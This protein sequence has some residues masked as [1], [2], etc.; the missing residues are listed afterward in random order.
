MKHRLSPSLFLLA[1][2]ILASACLP[3]QRNAFSP[4]DRAE[5]IRLA[6][7]RALVDQEIPDYNLLVSNGTDLIISTENIDPSQLPSLPG[8]S[9]TALSPAEI[10]AHANEEGDFL[11]LRFTH[12]DVEDA[13]TVSLGLGSNWAVSEDSTVGYLSGGGLEMQYERD[14]GSWSGEV[15]ARWIS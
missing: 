11:Y 12:F 14:A 9:L 1:I 5:I 15:I 8:F 3:T 4:V 13:D 2:M 7:E 6:L 10:Q